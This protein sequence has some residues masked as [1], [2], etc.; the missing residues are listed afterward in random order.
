MTIYTVRA[1][2]AGRWWSLQ[3]EEVPGAISQVSRLDQADQIR[4]AIAFVAQ[5]PESEVEIR[6]VPVMDAAT[7]KQLL[8]AKVARE[9]YEEA[10]ATMSRESRTA[11]KE[12]AAAGLS[13]RDVGSVMG[14]SFQRAQQLVKSE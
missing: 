5:V 4:E 7:A 10:L 14:V 11:A 1:E 9:A 3:C 6:V 8:I 2:R 13:L 12:L